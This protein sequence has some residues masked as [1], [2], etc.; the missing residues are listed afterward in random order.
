MNDTSTS[1]LFWLGWFFG[2]G[3]L[4]RLYNK[5][6]TSG[7]LWMC[8]WGFFGVGQFLDVVFIPSMV[9]EHNLKLRSQLGLSPEGVPLNQNVVNPSLLATPYYSE[10]DSQTPPNGTESIPQDQLMVRLAKAAQ[11]RE[12]KISVTQGVI[13][14]GTSFE[15]VESALQEMVKKGYVGIDNHPVNGV[16]IYEFLELG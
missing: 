5:K 3:G 1:Y 7:L 9:N 2:L 14:T 4:H 11:Q 13:D 15:A 16:V 6:L 8:T 12:G 10:R